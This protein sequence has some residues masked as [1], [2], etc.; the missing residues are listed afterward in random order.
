MN[1][2]HIAKSHWN[3][4]HMHLRI[5]RSVLSQQNIISQRFPLTAALDV[6]HTLLTQQLIMVVCTYQCVK[7]FVLELQ[8]GSNL[9]LVRGVRRELQTHQLYWHSLFC[10]LVFHNTQGLV[11]QCAMKGSAQVK[12]LD[13]WE[14]AEAIITGQHIWFMVKLHSFSMVIKYSQDLPECDTES[15]NMSHVYFG[16]QWISGLIWE[17]PAVKKKY[18]SYPFFSRF[19]ELLQPSAIVQTENK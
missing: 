9:Q 1:N 10:S 3:G 19:S 13:P 18:L 14:R 7:P 16:V 11:L 6:P 17:N 15:I 12:S 5:I 8:H 4:K 2:A